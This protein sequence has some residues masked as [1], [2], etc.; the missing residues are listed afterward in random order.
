MSLPKVQDINKTDT[1]TINQEIIKL[2]RELLNIKIKQK[3]Q[4]KVQ[5]HLFKHKKH[6]LAQ[7]LTIKTQIN[8]L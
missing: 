4:Q 2:K 7:L 8:N 3:T 1:E 6:S 5:P